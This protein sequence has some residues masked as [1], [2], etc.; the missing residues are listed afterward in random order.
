MEWLRISLSLAFGPRKPLILRN[1][2]EVVRR[3]YLKL[4][5]SGKK[6]DAM[7]RLEQAYEGCAV[8]VQ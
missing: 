1:S 2:P 6:A 7:A 8:T 5:Q 3:H 4:E